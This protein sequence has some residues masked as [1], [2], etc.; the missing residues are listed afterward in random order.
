MK[1]GKKLETGPNIHHRLHNKKWK[2]Q[3]GDRKEDTLFDLS[4]PLW[5]K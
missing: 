5:V 2:S 4:A 3:V 1:Y